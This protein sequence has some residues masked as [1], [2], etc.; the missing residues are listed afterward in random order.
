MTISELRDYLSKYVGEG[1]GDAEVQICK[2]GENPLEA[3]H[4]IKDAVFLE[5][6]DGDY[7]VVIEIG[8]AED[9]K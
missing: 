5:W 3:G 7:S 4:E 2:F 6:K 9:G 1:K 8:R